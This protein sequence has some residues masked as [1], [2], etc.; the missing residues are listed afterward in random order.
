MK[1]ASLLTLIAFATIST[2]AG[3]APGATDEERAEAAQQHAAAARAAG[4]RPFETLE[5][6]LVR[7]SDTDA[8]RREDAQR[9]ARQAHDSDLFE[10]MRG[11]AG[12]KPAPIT[13]TDTDSAR[14]VAA[15]QLHEQSLRAEYAEYVRV[16]AATRAV[17]KP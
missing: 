11:G 9:N 15:Q 4:L 6:E 1:T 7:I 14:A 10:V 17:I 5:P 2:A 8:A 13:V 3:A 16:Q 12:I